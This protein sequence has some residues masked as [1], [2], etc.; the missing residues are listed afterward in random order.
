VQ[1]GKRRR[2]KRAALWGEIRERG[3]EP[4]TSI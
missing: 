2:Q 1:K 3:R 4:K